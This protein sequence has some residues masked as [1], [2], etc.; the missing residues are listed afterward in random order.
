VGGDAVLT[1]PGQQVLRGMV[2]IFGFDLPA[3]TAS[4]SYV[5]VSR[6]IENYPFS[7]SASGTTRVHKFVIRYADDIPTAST[8]DWQVYTSS[9]YSTFTIPGCNSVTTQGQA[10]IATTTIPTD[11]TDWHL[12]VKTPDVPTTIRIY[13][14]FLAAYDQMP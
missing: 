12:K 11:G 10:Y 8:S 13:Q 2:P 1:E 5:T 4:T 9:E 3:Q 6:I 7:G 14:I